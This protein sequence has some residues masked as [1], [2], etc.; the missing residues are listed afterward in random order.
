MALYFEPANLVDRLTDEVGQMPGA[1]PLLSFTLSELYVNLAEKWRNQEPSDRALVIDARFDQEGGVAGSLTRKANEEY[2]TIGDDPDLGEAGQLTMRRVMLRML[3]LEGSETARR[4]VPDSELIYPSPEESDRVK[5]V[6]DHLVKVR[7]LVKGQLETGET[8]VEPAHD[9]LVRGWDRLQEWI[10]QSQGDLVLQ[11]RL[12]PTA[13]DWSTGKGGL[14]TREVARLTQLEKVLKSDNNWLN[15]LETKFVNCSI[16]QRLDELQEVERQRNEAIEGQIDAL[17]SLSETRLLTNDE[18]GSLIAGVKAGVQLKKAPWLQDKLGVQTTT[19][20]GQ[21]VYRVQERN[22]LQGHTNGVFD[23]S[24]SPDSELIATAS[25]DGTLKLWRRDGTLLK[26]LQE[27]NSWVRCLS[28]SPNGKMIASASGLEGTV[29]IWSLPDSKLIKTLTSNTGYNPVNQVSFSP[30][31]KTIAA[32]SYDNSVK[33]WNV[34]E[35]RLLQTFAH[36]ASS[37]GN[38]GVL[39]VSFHCNGQ[40]IAFTNDGSSDIEVRRVDSGELLKNIDG[41]KYEIRALSFS[42]D[43][44]VLAFASLGNTVKLWKVED[45]TLLKTFE[46]GDNTVYCLSFSH[47]GQKIAVA[48]RTGTVKV[49]SVQNE[50]LLKTFEGH[51]SAIYRI[52]FSHDDTTLASAS[53]DGSVKLWSL[54]SANTSFQMK[55]TSLSFSADGRNLAFVDDKTIKVWSTTDNQLLKT[56]TGHSEAVS[57]VSFSSDDKLIASG[58]NDKTIKL[59]NAAEGQLLKTLTG[60]SESVS[61]VSFSSDGKLIASGSNDKTIKLWRVADGQLL[62]TLAGHSEGISSMSFSPTDE[63]LI[64]Y[65][66]GWDG[67]VKLWSSDGSLLKTLIEGSDEGSKRPSYSPDG[68]M[69][70]CNTASGVK[71]WSNDGTLLKTFDKDENPSSISISLDGKMLAYAIRNSLKL[72]SLDGEENLLATLYIQD[73]NWNDPLLDTTDSG[74]PFIGVNFSPDGKTITAVRSNNS[75]ALWTTGG[76]FI[77]IIT[78]ENTGIS[79]AKFSLDG[80]KIVAI[81]DSIFS[82]T[83]DESST[84]TLTLWD[85]NL[86]KLLVQGCDWLHDYLNTNPNLSEEDRYLCSSIQAS[87]SLDVDDGRSAHYIH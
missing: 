28:F 13:N 11:Q 21:A 84:T 66:A 62:K 34:G 51:N 63:T 79:Y 38:G 4:R 75:I 32:A 27:E 86:H 35:G 69:I 80:K 8:Y 77:K 72:W 56:L 65:A 37:N 22:R 61:S 6:V 46:A 55:G 36:S 67:T 40:V 2:Q 53:A 58:S 16:Q 42:P 15:Q 33:L 19:A 24:F 48:G 64:S 70:A 5:Q 1:L 57:S 74:L 73:G 26:T 83:G 78:G 12:T 87:H 10:K 85:F 76:K 71:L 25:A 39:T 50:T 14:W 29:K 45:D 82:D 49:W 43:G 52:S 59:W 23:V 31:S 3:T 54:V 7:L 60:H 18:L 17:A 44:Q 30:D 20:L 41:G 47:D 9:F 81:G 68:R